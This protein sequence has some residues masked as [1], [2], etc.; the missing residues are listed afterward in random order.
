VFC[1]GRLRHV[2]FA[3]ARAGLRSE[4]SLRCRRPRTTEETRI[5]AALQ[6]A[7]R[8]GYEDSSPV[9]Q[10]RSMDKGYQVKPAE[11]LSAQRRHACLDKGRGEIAAAHPGVGLSADRALARRS[12]RLRRS[13]C[14]R[15]GLG[16]HTRKAIA[17]RRQ[18][19]AN[20]HLRMF[21]RK[22]LTALHPPPRE[23]ISYDR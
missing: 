10:Q 7:E 20:I 14:C 16:E 6:N 18:T 19:I 23:F 8:S 15:C 13:R 17:C 4:G 22:G 21:G 5:R 9:R 1:G 12:N 2:I 3:K 11:I